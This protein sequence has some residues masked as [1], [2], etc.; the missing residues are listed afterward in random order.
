MTLVTL[1]KKCKISSFLTLMLVAFHG[2]AFSSSMAVASQQYYQLSM[3]FLRYHQLA[4]SSA[5]QSLPSYDQFMLSTPQDKNV[6]LNQLLTATG[7]HKV[8]SDPLYLAIQRYQRR[9]QLPASGHINKATY[10]SLS[11]GP[12]E[13]AQLIAR[14]LK[15][16]ERL[17][18]DLG[19]NYVLVNVPDYSLQYV[20]RGEVK[21]SMRVIV[22]KP[23]RPTPLMVDTIRSIIVNPTWT[24]PSKIAFKD[25]LPKLKKQPNYLKK[26]NFSVFQ[27][28]DN[29]VV[30]VNYDDID[31]ENINYKNIDRSAFPYQLRQSSGS[32]NALGRFKFN[33]PNSQAIYLHDTPQKYLFSRQNRALSSGCV[34]VEKPRQLAEQLLKSNR[35]YSR[36]KIDQ[37]LN[38]GQMTTLSLNVPVPVYITYLTAWVNQDGEL[39]FAKDIYKMDKQ[40]YISMADQ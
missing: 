27:Y 37:I 13:K 35:H 30:T 15:R 18:D 38:S 17:P 16:L 20:E 4:Q 34:R 6:L 31:W 39:R 12:K 40:R 5:W 25:I 19:R 21:L 26:N 14:N 9:H 29:G 33:F 32:H 1:K 3:A 11:A 7:D 8:P 23:Y 36:R 2:E 28:K 10:L 22:G 24:V